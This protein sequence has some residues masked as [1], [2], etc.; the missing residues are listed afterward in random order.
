[1]RPEEKVGAISEARFF[2]LFITRTDQTPK[3][4]VEVKRA[5]FRWEVHGIDAFAYILSKPSPSRG[6]SVLVKVPIQIKSSDAG[7]ARF[8][9][10][11][12]TGDVCN[13][14]VT[15]VYT[16]KSDTYLR[17]RLYHEL[18]Q[19]RNQRITFDEFLSSVRRKKVARN[20]LKDIKRKSARLRH[21]RSRN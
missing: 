18:G 15:V 5:S 16:S 6:E 8:L 11:Y 1:M 14:L 17:Q 2:E 20:V 3:W 10:K 4:F 13:I 12:S 19:I 9:E 21:Y 7:K